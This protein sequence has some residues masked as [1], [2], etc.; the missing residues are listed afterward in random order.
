MVRGFNVNGRGATVSGRGHDIGEVG[1]T[2]TMPNGVDV[3]ALGE[4][5]SF[6]S[7]FGLYTAQTGGSSIS[8]STSDATDGSY[9]VQFANDTADKALVHD[10]TNGSNFAQGVVEARWYRNSGTNTF[11]GAV[12]RYQDSNNYYLAEH[13]TDGTEVGV[14]K[15]VG[16]NFSRVNRVNVSYTNDHS[17]GWHRHHFYEQ[18]GSVHHF[19][20]YN[21]GSGWIDIGTASDSAN[22]LT[23]GGGLGFGDLSGS[24]GIG[25]EAYFVDEMRV[26][27]P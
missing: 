1:H 22:D 17:W 5:E 6:E 21:D 23:G 3:T 4:P 15:V 25:T 20:Q 27:V 13:E 24:D 11:P 7:G 9:S 19:M 14:F 18:N 10:E 26:Y 2:I 16:G 12:F 8:R